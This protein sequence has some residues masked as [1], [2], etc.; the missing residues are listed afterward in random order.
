M[1]DARRLNHVAPSKSLAI[2]AGAIFLVVSAAIFIA[3]A[4]QR[5][6]YILQFVSFPYGYG[7][8]GYTFIA[9]SQ[10]MMAENSYYIDQTLMFSG[11]GSRFSMYFT[12][13][14]PLYAFVASMWAPF[15]GVLASLA[16]LNYLAWALAAYVA[17]RYTYKVFGDE[18]AAAIAVVLTAFGIGF[19]IHAHD[20]G[21]HL[22]PFAMYYLGALLIYESGVWHAA[23]PWRT[24]LA[25][26]AYLAVCTL[27]YSTGIVLT[28]AYALVAFRHNRWRYV[29]C[30]LVLGISS[31]YV[32]TV[33]LNVMNGLASGQWYWINVPQTEQALMQR[34]LAVWFSTMRSPVALGRMFVENLLQFGGVECPL[35]IAAAA[36]CW[37][38]QE[39]SREQRWF[40][41]VLAGAPIAVALVY[42]HVVGT[43]GYLSFGMSLFIYSSIAG[44]LGAWLGSRN[45]KRIV[46]VIALVVV[47][48]VQA[49]WSTSYLRGYLIPIKM[50]H[51]FGALTW[52]PPYIGH[53]RLPQALSLT[54]LEPTPVLF[55]GASSLSEGGAVT[56]TVP[57]IPSFTWR[58]GLVAR[59]VLVAYFAGLGLAWT[60]RSRLPII[61]AGA[62]VLWVTP[63]LAAKTSPLQPTPVYS[64]FDSERIRAG[65]RWRYSV[66]LGPGFI[67][68][69]RRTL[70]TASLVDFMVAGLQ[71]PFVARVSAGGREIASGDNGANVLHASMDAS[72]VFA[73]LDASKT[74]D[75]ELSA[76]HDLRVFGWQRPQLA[77]RHLRALQA[78]LS[79]ITA[80]P[81]FEVR[82]LD[83]RGAPL[84]VGF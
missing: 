83:S 26:G 34:S 7:L 31:Q 75:V 5:S 23:R 8:L 81:A 82:L 80:F 3:S 59:A 18:R 17:W 70:P 74:I 77:G 22:L 46:G 66:D 78:D 47:L 36:A 33:A 42:A 43:R 30:A 39:R 68:A 10:P 64:T 65:D 84:L 73:L 13:I 45:R 38:F 15:T 21:P 6:P 51:G 14:R 27:T 11:A 63:V 53:W 40:D 55:G 58:F 41:L 37:I 76:D 28:A 57:S 16:L 20:Y 49:G 67:S 9:G 1:T 71:P 44:T 48:G 60:G 54:D 12:S 72:R 50:F 62:C 4:N 25:I 52:L 19:V 2:G 35:L 69:V 79:A 29:L 24:H 32:W 56:A 61:A